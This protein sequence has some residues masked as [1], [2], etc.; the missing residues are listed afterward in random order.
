MRSRAWVAVTLA[1][2]VLLVGALLAQE[3]GGRRGMG[4]GRWQEMSEEERAQ[5]MERMQERRLSRLKERLDVSDDEWAVLSEPITA[6]LALRGEE[7]T[8]SQQLREAVGAEETTT[9]QLKQA[10]DKYRK[11]RK[12]IAARRTKLQA[13]L[14]E[15]VTLRQE[16]VLVLEG[17]LE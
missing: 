4:R 14:K 1:L 12:D 3:R 2:A 10:L 16:A 17:I 6:L 15:L 8:A 9:E 13:Q 7:F 11:A 5:M